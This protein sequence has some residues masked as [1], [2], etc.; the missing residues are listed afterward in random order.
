MKS[1][2]WDTSLWWF[3]PIQQLST[4]QLLPLPNK[5]DGGKIWK[6]KSEKICG[7]IYRQV[8]RESKTHAANKVKQG[9]HSQIPMDRLVCSHLQKSRVPWHITWED[10]QYDFKL[11]SLPSSFPGFF[12]WSWCHI[13]WDML[14]SVG[15][16]CPGCVL[17]Q[18]PM[19]SQPT[20]WGGGVRSRKVL[21][22]CE[23]CSAI[24]K[25]FPALSTL[26]LAQIQ[27]TAPF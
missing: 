24:T 10:K 18:F 17:S 21:A 15:A 5:Q 3:N 6:C 12:Y 1:S 22:P 26:S 14:W 7:L 4:M 16:S 27:I 9:I 25:K 20:H 19:N 11:F 2:S 13:V 23:P 8:N